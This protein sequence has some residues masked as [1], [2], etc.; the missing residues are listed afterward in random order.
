MITASECAIC[1]PDI[2]T[3]ERGNHPRPACLGEFDV[4]VGINLLR[5]GLISPK[6]LWSPSWMPTRRILAFGALLIQTVGLA[7]RHIHGTVTFTLIGLRN[8]CAKRLLKPIA[9]E[10]SSYFQRGERHRA[11]GCTRKRIKDIIDGVM[12]RKLRVASR[13]LPSSKLS[14]HQ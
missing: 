10:A 11:A 3:V 12:T 4:L 2:D 14:P 5:E 8:R 9:G 7:A 1:T 13:R 6:C